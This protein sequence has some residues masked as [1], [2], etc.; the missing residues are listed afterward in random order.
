[1]KDETIKH[2]QESPKSEKSSVPNSP[3]KTKVV[4]QK[5][6]ESPTKVTKAPNS[7]EKAPKSP[8]N[9]KRNLNEESMIPTKKILIDNSKSPTDAP[10][11]TAMKSQFAGK[12]TSDTTWED[13][14][15]DSPTRNSTAKVSTVKT[16]NAVGGG[17]KP[18]SL[19]QFQSQNSA[20]PKFIQEAAS[21]SSGFAKF[22]SSTTG[23]FLASPAAKT[24]VSQSF[25]Q[26]LS[27]PTKDLKDST[28]NTPSKLI[29]QV[30]TVSLD[31]NP[32][33]Q[34]QDSITGEEGETL[35]Y[36]TRLKLFSWEGG[37]WHERGIGLLKISE[38]SPQKNRLVMRS[39]VVLR[40]ILN[41][42]IQPEMPMHLRNEQYVEF[43]ASEN[44]KLMKFL[45]K[46][47][48][49]SV[50]TQFKEALAKATPPLIKSD[51][52]VGS[53]VKDVSKVTTPDA[54]KK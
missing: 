25:A 53:P 43:V 6:D 1:M 22:S 32:A 34:I 18:S 47:K 11:T 37:E 45:C 38:I 29:T 35:L 10:S 36:S 9:K 31:Q 14:D 46:L 30:K 21:N 2:K 50:A 52:K 28:L 24:G 19:G 33:F 54:K 15:P 5:L 44:G 12:T 39:D 7:P 23:S 13:L 17:I 41:V 8:E 48:N 27:T 3:S 42:R 51:D 26:L 16:V 4:S 20:V 40:L 49:N